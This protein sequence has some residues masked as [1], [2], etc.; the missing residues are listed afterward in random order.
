MNENNNGFDGFTEKLTGSQLT[1]NYDEPVTT[2]TVMYDNGVTVMSD[3]NDEIEL[4]MTKAYIGDKADAII[5]HKYNW[6]SA[7]V[8]DLFGPVWFFYRKMALIGFGFV[9]VTILVGNI[10]SQLGF[11]KASYLMGLIYLFVSN[12]I[13]LSVVKKRV[14][15]LREENPQMSKE[16]LIALSRGKGGVSVVAAVIYSILLALFFFLIIAALVAGLSS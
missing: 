13:Y 5:G 7:I 2:N 3:E 10:A 14:N 1:N 4:E 8:G 12:P 16:E 11:D 6:V 15:K 9:L